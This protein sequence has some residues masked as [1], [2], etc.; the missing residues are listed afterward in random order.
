VGRVLTDQ[1]AEFRD[2]A[3]KLHLKAFKIKRRIIG[4]SRKQ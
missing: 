3:L 4:L 1:G 2:E